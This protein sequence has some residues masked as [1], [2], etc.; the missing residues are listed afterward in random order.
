MNESDAELNS[1]GQA[2]KV[3]GPVMGAFGEMSSDVHAIAN[4]VAEQL[5]TKHYTFYAEKTQKW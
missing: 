1:Y 5:T 3:V 4:V 2:G